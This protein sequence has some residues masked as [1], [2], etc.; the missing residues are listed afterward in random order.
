MKV[1]NSIKEEFMTE[2]V[3]IKL[4]M[5]LLQLAM[6]KQRM[7]KNFGKLEIHGLNNG[8]KVDIS[9]LKL[10][11]LLQMQ[12]NVVFNNTHVMLLVL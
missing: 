2:I 11:S 7:A 12:A 1:S 4:I 10:I 5:L 6:A 9:D 8:V 3:L